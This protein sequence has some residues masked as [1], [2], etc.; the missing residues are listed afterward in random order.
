MDQPRAAQPW[1]RSTLPSAAPSVHQELQRRY[2]GTL[3]D[4]RVAWQ[5]RRDPLA[6]CVAVT[7]SQ[8]DLPEWLV[9][10]V[11]L[12]LYHGGSRLFSPDGSHKTPP[13]GTVLAQLWKSRELDARD[14]HRASGVVEARTDPERPQTWKMS[15]QTA[16]DREVQHGAPRLSP[17]AMKKSYGRVRKGLRNP[18][19]YYWPDKDFRDRVRAAVGRIPETKKVDTRRPPQSI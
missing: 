11:L 16:A 19:R 12:L 18:G 10:A 17:D 9:D 8:A 4:C 3:E 7:K 6:V 5:H 14:A 15:C 2:F 1:V 13:G